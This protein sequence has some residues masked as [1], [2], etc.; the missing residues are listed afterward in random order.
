MS[1]TFNTVETLLVGIAALFVGLFLTSQLNFLRKYNIPV[2]VT[3]GVVV[4]LL[5]SILYV[6]GVELNFTLDLRNFLLVSFFATVGLSARIRLLLSGGK[7]L[8]LL[9]GLA[10][11]FLFIQNYL[12][13]FLAHLTNVHAGI[14]LLAG[15]ITL[16]GGHGTGVAYAD[17]FEQTVGVKDALEIALASATYGLVAGGILGGPIAYFLIKRF[18]LKADPNEQAGFH[19]DHMYHHTS[20]DLRSMLEVIAIISTCILLGTSFNTWL[21]G[22]N[23]GFTLPDFVPVLFVGVIIANIIDVTKIYVPKQKALE[24]CSDLSLDLF[25]AMSLISLQLWTLIDLVGPL[26]VILSI[27][28]FVAILFVYFI[29]FRVA[30]KNYTASVI[31]AGFIG[32][33]LGA[34]PTAIANMSAVTQRHGLAPK[35]FIVIPLIGAFFI[36]IS[37]AWVISLFMKWHLL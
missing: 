5:I 19:S 14:G 10:I 20:V 24:L 17:I 9:I 28:T 23:L 15:S 30:G 8:L 29:V 16:S 35:A 37:N 11:I 32:F 6:F 2:P 18:R 13:L 27:Q 22:M 7:L 25:L 12:G 21:K 4:S 1:F 26:A 3:G 33:G 36:D 31:A 34:T